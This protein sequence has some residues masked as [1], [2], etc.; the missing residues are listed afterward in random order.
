[1][2]HEKCSSTFFSVFFFNGEV[3]EPAFFPVAYAGGDA[4]GFFSMKKD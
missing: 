3:A 4:D 1:V 2:L